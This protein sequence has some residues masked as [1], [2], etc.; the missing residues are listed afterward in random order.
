LTIFLATFLHSIR[1]PYCKL[2]SVLVQRQFERSV[3]MCH[4]WLVCFFV[5]CYADVAGVLLHVLIRVLFRISLSAGSVQ[6]PNVQ[7]RIRSV[8]SESVK[9][10]TF[11]L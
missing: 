10:A 11:S 7:I 6:L 4:R 2:L 1:L 3:F 8:V 5:S 9:I